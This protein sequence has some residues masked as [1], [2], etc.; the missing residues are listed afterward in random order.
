MKIKAIVFKTPALNESREF[1][2]QRIGLQIV[3]SSA[4][5]FVLNAKGTRLVFIDSV[6]DFEIELYAEDAAADNDDIKTFKDPN[7]I[8]II[9]RNNK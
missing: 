7:G 8:N 6:D 9:L 1:F 5:H 4:R 3:E 2:E